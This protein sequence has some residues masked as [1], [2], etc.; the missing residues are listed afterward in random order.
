MKNMIRMFCLLLTL[1]LVTSLLP[2]TASAASDYSKS[3]LNAIVTKWNNTTWAKSN[4]VSSAY[5]YEGAY[6]CA[7]FSRYAFMQLYGHTDGLSN[8]NNKVTIKNYTSVSSLLN[9]LKSTAAPGDAIRITNLT[10]DHT[11]ILHLYDITSAG[12]FVVY[13]SNYTGASTGSG[14]NKAR[15]YTYAS[16]TQMVNHATGAKVNDG[17]FNATIEVKVIH[18]T[19]NA[20]K[21]GSFSGCTPACASH[22][23]KGGICTKCGHE[24]ALTYTNMTSTAFMVTK[25]GGAPIWSRP[26][27]NNSTKEMTMKAG[28]IVVA[29]K[30]TTNEDGNLWYQLTTGDW[31]FSGNVKKTTIPSAARYISNT[32]G[33]L[34]MRVGAGTSYK[35]LTLIPEG[36]MVIMDASTKTGTWVKVTY[37][38]LTGYVS[39]NYLTT[40]VP[41]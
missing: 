18:S 10:N 2:A 9:F 41:R 5:K 15:C 20:N 8:K 17:K 25:T 31:I 28:S 23:Y 21:A 11:H 19:K 38:G 39:M 37:N 22:T 40:S 24:Y 29:V 6:Q 26:Y 13:E 1:V 35:V 16:L 30:K 33:G 34:N 32:S 3:T 4:A 14:H 36:S 27:S 7:A 12:K